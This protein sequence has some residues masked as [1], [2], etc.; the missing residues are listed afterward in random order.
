MQYTW[1]VDMDG[2]LCDFIAGFQKISGGLTPEEYKSNFGG[3]VAM[4]K[5]INTYGEDWWGTLPWTPDG[6][7]L[8]TAIKHLNPTL[9]SSASTEHTGGIGVRGKN[10]WSTTFLGA[11]VKAIV[12]DNRHGKKAYAKANSVL[13]DDYILNVSDWIDAGGVGIHHI[14]AADT[15]ETIK[16]L[17]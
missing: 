6:Q 16:K 13:I 5:L 1:Y 11:E 8:W 12:T 17:H 2:V 9:L 4:W 3:E 7:E 14:T 10:K 15:L